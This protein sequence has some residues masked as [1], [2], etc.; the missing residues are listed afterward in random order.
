[1]AATYGCGELVQLDGSFRDSSEW[2]GT[3]SA[4]TPPVLF[5]PL[6]KLFGK[7]M[8]RE[9]R[10]IPGGATEALPAGGAVL[11][12]W[13]VTGAFYRNDA[14]RLLCGSGRPREAEEDD[15]RLL[16]TVQILI[17]KLPHSRSNLVLWSRT[18]TGAI[19]GIGHATAGRFAA[20]A[21]ASY[22]TGTKLPPDGGLTL[23]V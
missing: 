12:V 11:Q 15:H 7:D 17:S 2:L 10:H 4:T 19:S 9:T 21:E 5:L 18:D 20:K 23:T 1:M 6:A 8:L 14:C 3:R 22:L 13:C 16:Q